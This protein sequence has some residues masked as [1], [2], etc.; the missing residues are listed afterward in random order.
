MTKKKNLNIILFI[1]YKN[2]KNII[3]LC[4]ETVYGVGGRLFLNKSLLLRV[5]S[6]VNVVGSTERNSANASFIADVTCSGL[7]VDI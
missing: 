7:I 2:T 4:V 6:L 5:I 1:G 3:P